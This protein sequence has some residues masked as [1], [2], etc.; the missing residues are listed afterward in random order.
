M[1]SR[2]GTIFLLVGLL[3]GFLVVLV[4]I[5]RL[6]PAPEGPPSSSY[7][8]T[9]LGV[10]AYA[11]L[12]DRAGVT[13]RQV[14]TPIAEREPREG[15]TLVILDPDVMEPEEAEAIRA[16]VEGGGRLVLG[17]SSEVAW[18]EQLL[19][20]PPRWTS[21]ASDEHEPLVPLPGVRTVVSLDGTGFEELGAALPMLGPAG[22]P[23]AA[24]ATLGAGQVVLLADTSPLTN[25][26][27]ARADNAAFSLA[28]TGDAPVAFLET[29]HGYGV[30]RGFGGLPSSIKWALLGLALT[31]LVALWAAGKRFGE[32][33]DEDSEPPP[34]RVEYV[35]ALAGSLARA[36]PEKEHT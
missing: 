30:S 32:P 28:L 13:V 27:L 4:V 20:E 26:G 24:S 33:E 15:E 12:L 34:P 25:R 21:A 3:A 17:A 8:T 23:L 18:I 11:A 10:A 6:S 1:S 36:K 9:P 35:D 16:W 7:A 31:S 29:V 5:D 19:D 14:R 2:R 22:S